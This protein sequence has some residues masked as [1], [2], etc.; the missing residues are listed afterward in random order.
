MKTRIN[1]YALRQTT[2]RSASLGVLGSVAHPMNEDGVYA[3]T[4]FQDGKPVAAFR[5]EVGANFSKSQ[6]D[7][8]LALLI[9]RRKAMESR[10]DSP[11]FELVSKG[12]LV[13]YVSEGPGGFHVA[14]E[15]AGRREDRA[16]SVFDSRTLQQGDLFIVTL[17]RP[18]LYEMH[19]DLGKA[20][21]QIKVTYPKPG[22]N[23]YV[24]AEPARV[25]VT[26]DGF[27]PAEV[28]VGA[29]QGVVFT[30]STAKASLAVGLAQPD[31]GPRKK[32]ERRDKV[33]WT[34]PLAGGREA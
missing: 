21:G 9:P 17:L 32:D 3:G 1:T 12:Y 25:D 29:A 23:P 33:R 18:G 27:R 7:V 34:N 14:L 5:I 4:V 28:S 22:K 30:V 19:D 11:S 6:A 8:D 16:G 20:K 26:A 15:R 2:V 31:D 24:P 10:H 13:M